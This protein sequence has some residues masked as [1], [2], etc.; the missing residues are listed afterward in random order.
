MNKIDFDF[1]KKQEYLEQE[2]FI[3]D[4]DAY[5]SL[6][7]MLLLEQFF[8]LPEINS[9][10]IVTGFDIENYAIH[11][12][13]KH[14]EACVIIDIDYDINLNKKTPETE[15]K[16]NIILKLLKE[17]D[18]EIIEY[19]NESCL[20]T[21]DESDASSMAEEK[22][23][24]LFF[25]YE[26]D[27][28]TLTHSNRFEIYNNIAK[29]NYHSKVLPSFYDFTEHLKRNDINSFNN[30][31]MSA[32]GV[33]FQLIPVDYSVIDNT[34]LIFDTRKQFNLHSNINDVLNYLVEGINNQI[35][36][37]DSSLF[38]RTSYQKDETSIEI[39]NKSFLV[40]RIDDL[41]IEGNMENL[42]DFIKKVAF[43]IHNKYTRNQDKNIG[44]SFSEECYTQFE[45]K[46]I[47]KSMSNSSI[48]L[49]DK[50]KKRL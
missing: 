14:F 4:Y 36:K 26:D 45:K 8:K 19:I 10:K 32:Y 33:D 5:L 42:S 13:G 9:V 3:P 16:I 39:S 15:N 40:K 29:F 23:N 30:P 35:L 37:P 12:G 24:L 28:F 38:F 11:G 49:N 21:E 44:T 18:R 2:K 17:N 1:S 34:D 20:E 27:H 7:K 6:N 50:M 41:H 47:E 22:M 43:S 46:L 31:T 48:S 25:L